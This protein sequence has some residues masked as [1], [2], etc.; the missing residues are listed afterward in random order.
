MMEPGVLLI[1]ANLGTL[2]E[3]PQ[4]MLEV[5]MSKLYETIEKFNPSFIALHCQEVGGK[6]FKKCMKEVS[7]FV[8]HLMRSS[9]MEQY[10]RAAMYLDEDFTLDNHFTALG[11][12]YFVHNSVKNIQCFDFK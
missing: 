7:S 11:N 5:W 9:S 3:K 6:K 4:E 12:I 2:F 1:T 10:D 8:S